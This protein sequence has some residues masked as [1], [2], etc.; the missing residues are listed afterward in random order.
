MES[1]VSSTL[2]EESSSSRKRELLEKEEVLCKKIR[3]SVIDND[4]KAD[5]I[6][7]TLTTCNES[8]THPT[9]SSTN[10]ETWKMVNLRQQRRLLLLH[11]AT[12]CRI[13]IGQNCP[14]STRCSETKKVCFH[15]ENCRDEKCVFPHC[16]SS[17]YLISHFRRCKDDACE[18]CTPVKNVI[19][20][21]NELLPP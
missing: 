9:R 19:R 1:S 7:S 10:S 8:E 5:S 16:V 20:S 14:V 17:R 11:H 6:A 4:Y 15:I 21:G 3:P 12:L 18:L 2:S 13:E